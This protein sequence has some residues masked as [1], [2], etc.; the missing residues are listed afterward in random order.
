MIGIDC[1]EDGSCICIDEVVIVSD[2]EVSEDPCLVKVTQ[3]DHVLDPSH[4]GWV[5]RLDPTLRGQPL[6]LTVV[7]NNLN[8]GEQKGKGPSI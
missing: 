8:D 4:R 3:A 5:H 2:E 1:D 6:L 7:V